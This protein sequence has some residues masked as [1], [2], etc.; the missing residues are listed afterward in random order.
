[1]LDKWLKAGVLEDGQLRRTSDGT[2]QGGVISPL[3][4]NIYLHEVLDR[5]FVEQVQPLMRG[6]AHLIRYA[7]D[8]VIVF[9]DESDARR[10][11]EVL[12]KRFGKS[13]NGVLPISPD[14]W[15][16]RAGNRPGLLDTDLTPFS[17]LHHG[18]LGERL[19]HQPQEDLEQLHRIHRIRVPEKDV[20]FGV[21]AAETL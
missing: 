13:G 10:V 17:I 9:G 2:P 11:M 14:L 15:G 21:P 4:A 20:E 5:W 6:P 19:I 1:M 12:P 8:F 18:L 7:D 16:A 3:L